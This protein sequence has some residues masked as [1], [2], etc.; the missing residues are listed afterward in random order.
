MSTVDFWVCMGCGAQVDWQALTCGRCGRFKDSKEPIEP[1]LCFV[2]ASN[3]PIIEAG[4][5]LADIVLAPLG[6]IKRRRASSRRL[7][8][9]IQGKE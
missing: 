8:R 5:E 1:S 7:A 6:T 2:C 4:K 9:I 3:A